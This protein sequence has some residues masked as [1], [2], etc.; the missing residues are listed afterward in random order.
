MIFSSTEFL[1]FLVAV[2]LLARVLPSEGARRNLLL[3]ASYLFYGWWDWRF[4]FLMFATSTLDYAVG[5]SLER[6]ADSGRRRAL[7]IG[8]LVANLGI[9]AGF[10]YANFC[11]DSLRPVLGAA[12]IP[13]QHLDIVLPVGISFFT[14][15]SMS[16]TVDVY[17]RVLPATRSYRDLLLFV[18]FF[19]QLIAGP[20]V[21]GSEFLPQLRAHDHRPRWD[22]VRRGLELFVRGFVKKVL[23]ADSLALF[24]DPV[25]AHPAGFAPLS[26][27]LAVLAYAGQIYYDFSGYTD[28]ATGCGRMFGFDF[29]VNFR[30]PYTA[31]SLTEFWRR[32]HITLSTWLRD[33][34]YVPLGGNRR[35]RGRTHLN[36]AVTMLL[37]GLWHGASWTFVAWGAWHGAGLVLDRIRTELR[38]GRPERPA[39]WRSFAGWSTTFLFVLVGW[40]LFRAPDFAT[41]GLVLRKL[42]FAEP[43]GA[44]W[45][46]AQAT[47]VLGA[48]VLLHLLVVRARERELL[49]D[50]RDP[51]AWVGVGVALALVVL[52]SPFSTNPFIYFQF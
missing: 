17:R 28:M 23:F 47:A 40:V 31:R 21:R 34:L 12:G 4:T 38:G 51:L 26:V 24:A 35:G 15:Q 50:L 25:F 1:L 33:Y 29:P 18:S 30:H 5:R 13:V 32:W 3:G 20:I 45:V 11:L 7:L 16:Y 27:W 46:Q 41:A 42:A 9:L 6:M 10:K 48:A 39:A 22:G 37:G 19:P 52:F 49:P 14:F 8:S 43:G 44:H 36:L 2:L